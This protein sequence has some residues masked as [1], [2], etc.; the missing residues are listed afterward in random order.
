M[1][2]ERRRWRDIGVEKKKTG[3]GL[4]LGWCTNNRDERNDELFGK[5][6]LLTTYLPIGTNQGV[7]S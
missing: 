5:Q 1:F 2:R 6:K 4:R 7:D 3:A